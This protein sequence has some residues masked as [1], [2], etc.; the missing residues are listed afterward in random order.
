LG[1]LVKPHG[2]V[3]VLIRRFSTTTGDADSCEFSKVDLQESAAFSA[4]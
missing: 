1:N 3:R 4:E 2:H